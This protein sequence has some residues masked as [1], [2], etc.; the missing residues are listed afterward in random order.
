M[1]PEGERQSH[2]GFSRR[3][4]RVLTERQVMELA[5]MD[6]GI[7]YATGCVGLIC[8]RRVEDGE[9]LL[10]PGGE[11][12]AGKEVGDSKYGVELGVG[13]FVSVRR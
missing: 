1:V 12:A 8:V 9:A 3:D 2:Q 10:R 7:G 11:D 5:Q 4:S 6:G 13:G